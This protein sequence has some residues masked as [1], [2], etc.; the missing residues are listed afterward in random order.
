MS[1]NLD[2]A[3]FLKIKTLIFVN[4][5]H[6]EEIVYNWTLIQSIIKTQ[7]FEFIASGIINQNAYSYECHLNLE[8]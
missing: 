7:N 3:D 2:H 6:L 1:L 8:I 5:N 4:K